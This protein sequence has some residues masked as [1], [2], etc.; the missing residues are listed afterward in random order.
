VLGVVLLHIWGGY[1]ITMYTYNKG[2][3]ICI[4]MYVCMYVCICI[5]ICMY[6]Y[7]YVYVY[8]C[9]YVY[10]WVALRPA[11]EKFILPIGRGH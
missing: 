7:V 2:V 5:C 11:I 3:P 10:V 9:M 8:V 1:T 6:V 4:C